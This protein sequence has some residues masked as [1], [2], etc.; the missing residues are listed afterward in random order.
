M[1][2]PVF[3]GD[4]Q[5]CDDELEDLLSQL[6]KAFGD[7][8][9]EPWFAGDL[10]NRG[11]GSLRVLERVRGLLEQ[12]G[13][14]V[15]LGNHDLAL[16]A[17][18]LGLRAL[19]PDDTFGDVLAAPGA[20]G[21]IEWLRSLPLALTGRLGAR[22]FVLVHAAV[23]P[24]WT[25]EAV[26]EGA[27]RVEARLGAPDPAEAR[28]LLEAPRSDP[29]RDALGRMTRCRS[30]DARGSWRSDEPAR[31]EDA[32]HRR[33]AAFGHGYGVVYGHWATQGLQR[34]PGLRGL[35]T[36]CVHRGLGCEGRLTAWAPDLRAPDPFA[37]PDPGRLFHAPA[38]RD[39][40][41][42]VLEASGSVD[43]S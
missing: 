23:A 22:P 41:R 4:I 6:G 7:G 36:G 3:V 11:P 8:G 31:P 16:V 14:G 42:E 10:V 20:R 25:L 27:R 30:V 37:L 39:Y 40:F 2:Q 18:H 32:W 34:A 1:R 19:R 24:E 33:W 13:G 29:D 17:V 35:D 21:W 15:V 38:R 43:S 9:F 26:A 5:G 28:A 12:A